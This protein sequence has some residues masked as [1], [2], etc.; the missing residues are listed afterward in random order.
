MSDKTVKFCHS[1]D[2]QARH[3]SH[4]KI[5]PYSVWT[6]KFYLGKN[7]PVSV[8]RKMKMEEE[9]TGNLDTMDKMETQI[10]N[11]NQENGNI[12]NYVHPSDSTSHQEELKKSLSHREW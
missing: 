8:S 11:E 10:N 3:N 6:D 9:V 5:A 7:A 1:V 12:E 2:R 4:H